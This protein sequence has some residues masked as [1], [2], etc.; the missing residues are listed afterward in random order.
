M[1]DR[2]IGAG[3]GGPHMAATGRGRR[4]YP[5]GPLTLMVR[6]RSGRDNRGNFTPTVV[7]TTAAEK[8][9]RGQPTESTYG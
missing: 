6:L 7:G 9:R 8:R 5:P 3:G 1:G 2:A 4:T